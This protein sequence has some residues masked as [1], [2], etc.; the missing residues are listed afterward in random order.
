MPVRIIG[1]IRL[2]DLMAFERYRSQVGATVARYN[3]TVTARGLTDKTYWNE[4][5]CAEFNAY[6]ELSFPSSEDA[7]QWACSPEYQ[8]LLPVRSLAMN[9]SLIRIQE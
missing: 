1:L 9:L 6:V 4:L 8:A 5:P 3:G 7:D 2:K